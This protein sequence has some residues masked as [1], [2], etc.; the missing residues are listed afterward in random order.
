[1][2]RV[3]A[4][5]PLTMQEELAR[6]ILEAK[7]IAVRVHEVFPHDDRLFVVDL[8]LPNSNTVI[9][10]W[11]SVSRRGN[12]LTWTEKNGCYVEFKFWK[13]KESYPG[14]R[15]VGLVEAPQVDDESLRRVVGAV[16]LH[17]DF[18]AF[19]LEEFEEF[20][21]NSVRQVGTNLG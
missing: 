8:F 16:M 18:M 4:L 10:C 21:E 7:G 15:C 9:E 2:S 3:H 5:V 17:A 13:L 19:S 20:V 1:M 11:K 12:A 6:E 14:I